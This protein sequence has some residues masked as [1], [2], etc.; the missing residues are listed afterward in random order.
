MTAFDTPRRRSG[1]MLAVEGV[2]GKPLRNS[3]LHEQASMVTSI[4]VTH[5]MW[6]ATSSVGEIFVSSFFLYE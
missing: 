6:I 3:S 1:S 2:A 5:G 4:A